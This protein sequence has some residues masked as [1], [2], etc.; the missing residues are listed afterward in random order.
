MCLGILFIDKVYVVGAHELDAAFSAQLGNMFV[1]IFLY[2]IDLVIGTLDGGF[3]Q[4]KLKII[5]LAKDALE[6]IDRCLGLLQLTLSDELWNLASQAGRA[7]DKS[8]FVFFEL[9]FVGAGGVII[10]LRPPF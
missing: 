3:M 2:A 9:H 4:L 10:A 7:D 8:L 6:P 5:I 1:N